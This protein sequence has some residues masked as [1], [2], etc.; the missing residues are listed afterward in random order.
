MPLRRYEHDGVQIFAV[1][2][3]EDGDSIAQFDNPAIADMFGDILDAVQP[4]VVHLHSVQWLS[5]TVARVCRERGIPYVI[6]VHDAWWLCPRQFMVTA[7]DKYCGQTS[8]DI[9]VCEACEPGARHLQLRRDVLVEALHGAALLLSPSEAHRALYV[10]NGIA[11][12]HIQVAPNGVRLPTEALARPMRDTV[13]FGYVGGAVAVKGFPLVRGAFEALRRP[14]WELVLVD[15]TLSLGFPSVDAKN[16]K[17]RGGIEIVSAYAQDEMD[18]FFA[19]ID[20]LLFPS[21]WKE[22]FGLTVREALV[23]DV[24]VVT[25]N[26]GGA[27]EAVTEGVNGTIIPLDGRWESLRDAIEALLDRRPWQQAD[28]RR[29]QA[30]NAIMSYDAQA[31][32]LRATLASVV[33]TD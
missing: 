1:P 21:Q 33:G 29:A 12:G 17:V 31:V 19:D 8:I 3:V 5:A 9:H 14:D 25:T 28:V 6:T 7:A 18:A 24:W 2:V 32:A 26:G 10:A 23:R 4:D 20:V 13:R 16:W 30:K 15:N 27:A 22:S 11:P